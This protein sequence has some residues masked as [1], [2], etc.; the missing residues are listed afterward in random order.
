MTAPGTI[1][2]AVRDLTI[3]F[4]GLT[5]VDRASFAVHE[6]EILSLI[7]PNGAGKT[8]AFNAITGY[9][10][11]AGGE[12]TWR[13]TRLNRLKPNEIAALASASISS[14]SRTASRWPRTV[15]KI[16]AVPP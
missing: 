3:R 5:A 8:T 2:L 4:G 1:A 15:A 10:A 7:G 13:G 11:P 9:I 12:I 6:G 16:S 14:N